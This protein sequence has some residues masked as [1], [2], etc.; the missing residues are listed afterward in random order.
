M[1]R[2][3]RIRRRRPTTSDVSDNKNVV[4]NAG[5]RVYAS[6]AEPG[7]QARNKRGEGGTRCAPG[8]VCVHCWRLAPACGIATATA[9]AWARMASSDPEP[10]RP[11]PGRA[12]DQLR[13]R[14]EIR[15]R[16]TN[17][18]SDPS[19]TYGNSSDPMAAATGFDDSGWQ[20]V[21]LPHD[22]SIT[23]L[24]RPRP[25]QRDRL[26]PRRP[27]L[28]PQDIHP[29]GVDGRQADLGRLRRRV[30]QLLRVPERPAARQSP[31]RLHGIQLRRQQA[32]AHRRRTPNVLAVVVQNLEPSSRWYS[33]SGITR[34]V[35]L[36]VT[37]PVHVARWGTFVT[38]PGLATTIQSGFATRTSRPSCQ[39]TVG[40]TPSPT[41]L[42]TVRDAS[43]RLVASS[44]S[45]G[46][47]IPAGA[48]PAT[49]P[50]SGSST[51]RCGRRPTPTCTR[52][53]QIVHRR[54]PPVDST[55]RRSASAGSCSI[56]A[57]ASC[58]T[59]STSSSRASTC[60]TTRARSARSTTTTRC[61]GR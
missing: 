23:Q 25:E 16:N 58:S 20:P 46:V 30:R 42:Y 5:G 24:P 12:D 53:R 19:G 18:T 35:H 45:T 17:D 51:R 7:A 54:P 55:T 50:T 3:Y 56:R 59:A 15:A 26:L 29:A 38:T 10:R 48:A 57:R 40:R 36:T 2:D 52:F 31:V 44:R 27:R 22:W 61:G 14:L 33:G 32:R 8:S 34:H 11:Q 60:T 28:V 21:T 9:G 41:V 6:P 1:G 43:G 39:T 13:Q 37:D 47:A 49:A 4:R